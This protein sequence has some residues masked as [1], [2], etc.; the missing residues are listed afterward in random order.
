MAAPAVPP[1]TP[2][3]ARYPLELRFKRELGIA[4]FRPPAS[5]LSLGIDALVGSG[6]PTW[7]GMG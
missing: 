4:T 2:P 6:S 3:P 5:N 1:Q 7:V